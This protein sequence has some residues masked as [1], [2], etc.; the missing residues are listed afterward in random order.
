[1]MSFQAGQAKKMDWQ[2]EMTSCLGTAI[3][4]GKQCHIVYYHIEIYKYIYYFIYKTKY[5]KNPS[6]PYL[7]VVCLLFCSF[8]VNFCIL[9][10]G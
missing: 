10:D 4:I 8:T 1:M 3:Q 9:Q 5:Y 7:S 2:P 6:L